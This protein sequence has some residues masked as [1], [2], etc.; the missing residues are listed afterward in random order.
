MDQNSRGSIPVHSTTQTPETSHCTRPSNDTRAGRA[1]QIYTHPGIEPPTADEKPM[2]DHW[3]RNFFTI[4]AGQTFSL[5]GSAAVQFTLI[6]W[7]TCETKSAIVLSLA[8]LLAFLP[9]MLLGPFAGVW[10]DRMKRK[11]VIIIS[12]L[13]MGVVAGVL[14]LFFLFGKPSYWVVCAAIGVRALGGVFHTPALQAALPM[15]VPPDQ[16]V[17]ANALNQFLQSGALML[18]PVLGA[19][20]YASLS[21]PTILFTDIAFAIIASAAVVLVKIPDP[22]RTLPKTATCF[23]AQ[24]KEGARVLIKDRQI[25]VIT[26]AATASM[27][28]FLP[29]SSLYPLITAALNGD[30]LHAGLIEMAYALGMALFSILLSAIGRFHKKFRAIHIALF[31]LGATSFVL[32]MLPARLTYFWAFALLCALM[33]GSG[34]LFHIPFNAYLQQSVPPEVQGRVFSLVNSLMAF[35]MPMGLVIAGPIAQAKGVLFWFVVCGVAKMGISILSALIVRV[36]GRKKD[37]AASEQTQT[38]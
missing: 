30:A 31:L 5:I 38:L 21:L 2:Y 22:K 23:F 33:G 6:W 29:L 32:G 35:A 12:D 4:A 13:F 16:L 17:R 18:G 19:A 37:T 36:L 11:N 14:A 9:Q 34:S 20:K 26:L 15:L 24:M 27:I 25:V 28:C 3:K 1:E 8:G 10:I 7:L